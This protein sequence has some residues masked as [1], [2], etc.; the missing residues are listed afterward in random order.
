M[1]GCKNCRS[2]NLRL[3]SMTSYDVQFRKKYVSQEDVTFQHDFYILKNSVEYSG[4][5]RL[6]G[7][8]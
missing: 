7:I 6:A 4:D 2:G 8:A 1:I 3:A 5:F